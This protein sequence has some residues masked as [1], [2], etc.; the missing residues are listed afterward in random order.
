MARDLQEQAGRRLGGGTIRHHLNALSNFYRR[1][2]EEDIVMPGFNPVA[3]LMEKPAGSRLE[4]RW[5]EMP[6]AALV[7]EAGRHL[8]P[9]AGTVLDREAMFR[10]RSEFVEFRLEQ[11][12]ERLG[13]RLQRLGFHGPFVTGNVT[14]REQQVETKS[15]APT[16]VEV[17]EADPESGRPDSNRRRPAWEA[18]IL[19]LNY[20][21]GTPR[22][23]RSAPGRVKRL[24]VPRG[25][26][27]AP[28]IGLAHRRLPG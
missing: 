21:R 6:Q 13:D 1:A 24:L 3:A 25:L 2:Q 4:A 20:A 16:E 11:H 15:P 7:L 8:P 28:K 22:N 10:Y 26:E 27:E 18:G 12:L 17:G 5:L 9:M 23:L 14:G 19:P